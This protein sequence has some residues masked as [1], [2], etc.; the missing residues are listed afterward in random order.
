MVKQYVGARYVPKFASPLDW[1]AGTSYEALTIVTFNNASYTSKIQVPPTVGNPA[2]NPKY[3]A[4]TG[5]YN[6]QVEQYRQEAVKAKEDADKATEDVVKVK[7]DVTNNSNNITS[8]SEKHKQDIDKVEE[9]INAN[10]NK[11]TNLSNNVALNSMPIRDFINYY[12]A[13]HT[14]DMTELLQTALN[15]C[16]SNNIILFVPGGDY[17]IN[18]SITLPDNAKLVGAGMFS[19]RFIC[20]SDF[21]VGNTPSFECENYF[22][23]GFSANGLKDKKQKGINLWGVSGTIEYV[24]MNSF[25]TGFYMAEPDSDYQ[26]KVNNKEGHYV[27]NCTAM[28]CTLGFRSLM[29]DSLYNNIVCARCVNGWRGGSAKI[30]NLHIWGFSVT[31][32][33]MTSGQINN[34]EIEGCTSISPTSI[35]YL[36]SGNIEIN[37][38]YFWNCRTSN[39]WWVLDDHCN[40]VMRN[41]IIGNAGELTSANPNELHAIYG[42]ANSLIIDGLIDDS[43]NAG[44]LINENATIAKAIILMMSKNAIAGCTQVSGQKHITLS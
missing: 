41:V 30:N 26:S 10:S 18:S 35:V 32:L 5:N 12:G 23:Y 20:K 13:T 40:V 1:A 29:C 22:L 28:Y 16:A 25:D 2:N 7:E 6:A 3:W 11:I 8:L 21:L 39:Y 34:L 15:E 42:S 38:F 36:A 14:E 44:R 37:N 31:A 17:T 19:T 27:N 24:C 43:Y 9:E 33:N 4:L